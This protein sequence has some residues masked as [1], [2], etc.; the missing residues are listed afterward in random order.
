MLSERFRK[1]HDY[2]VLLTMETLKND[3]IHSSKESESLLRQAS[4]LLDICNDIREEIDKP[5]P[6]NLIDADALL[7]VLEEGEKDLAALKEYD[8]RYAVLTCIEFVKEAPRV[9]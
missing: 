9:N 6:S 1:V 3:I 2:F 7:K 8:A 5:R 4:D